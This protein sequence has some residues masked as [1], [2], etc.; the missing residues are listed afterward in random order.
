MQT[1]RDT[2]Q[3]VLFQARFESVGRG[4]PTWNNPS[5]FHPIVEIYTVRD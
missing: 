5:N 2:S 3:N 4:D 1:D